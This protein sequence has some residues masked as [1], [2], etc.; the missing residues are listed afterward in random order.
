MIT[1]IK[2]DHLGLYVIAGGYI[3]R[4]FFGTCFKEGDTVKTHGFSGTLSGVTTPDKPDTHHFRKNG[5]YEYWGFTGLSSYC[6]RKGLY[7][8]EKIEEYTQWYKD[9]TFQLSPFQISH[10]E[11]F[12]K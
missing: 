7:S 5:M 9:D 8:K 1:K 4:P 10:N 12:I 2:S 3:T 6:F 11:K